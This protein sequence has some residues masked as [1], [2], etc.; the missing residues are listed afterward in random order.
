MSQLI[1]RYHFRGQHPDE[2]ILHIIHRH[3]FNILTHFF[4]IIVIA[5]LLI[6][7]FVSI[8]LFFSALIG[9]HGVLIFLFLQNTLFLFLW[10]FA[11]LVWIDYY[12]DVWIITNERI[13]NIE[14]KGLFVRH[15]SELS[16]SRIQDITAEIEGVLPTV[17]N[18][19]DVVI[20]TAGAN[21][22]F[23]FHQVPDPYHIKDIVMRLSR[24]TANPTS[25]IMQT[26]P[27]TSPAS[28]SKL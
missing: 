13:V 7:S 6:T 14:Q 21:E 15:I 12:F 1:H 10:I 25:K 23:A 22:R 4:V 8:P 11:F 18:F 3:W 24:G 28:E 20:Q 17:L 2:E 16:F 27:L 19:G 26:P 9:T 5:L